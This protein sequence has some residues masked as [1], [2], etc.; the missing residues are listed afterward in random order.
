MSLTRQ[1]PRQQRQ[2]TPLPNS[3]RIRRYRWRQRERDKQ[4]VTYW[5]SG[6]AGILHA[7]ILA[8]AAN[9]TLADL[10]RVVLDAKA[11]RPYREP[12]STPAEGE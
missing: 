3:E 1:T 10:A 11:G 7:E 5:L 12:H 8:R 6:E 4:V 9:A 2:R